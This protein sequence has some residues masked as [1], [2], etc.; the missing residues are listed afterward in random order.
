MDGANLLRISPDKGIPGPI[1]YRNLLTI[2]GLLLVLSAPGWLYLL[3]F[4]SDWFDYSSALL[5]VPP[6]LIIHSVLVGIASRQDGFL[7]RVMLVGTLAKLACASAFLYMAFHLFNAAADA[8]HYFDQGQSYFAA[9]QANG[10]FLLLQPFWSNN[11]IYMLSGLVQTV[12]GYDLQTT[13]VLFALLSFW[14]EYFC[15]RA[16][17]TAVPLEDRSQPAL[18]LFLLPSLAFW[19]API[20]KD[21]AVLL[22]IGLTAY[23]L[24]KLSSE[25]VV[26]G[27]P[28]A[29]IGIG[30]VALVRPH[31]A[32][33]I[34]TAYAFPFLASRTRRGLGGMTIKV[35]G[36]PLLVAV[37]LYLAFS[38]QSFLQL[39][40]VSRSGAVLQKINKNSNYGGSAFGG[41]ASP[42]QRV[43]AA[44]VLF[45]RP[46]P[47]EV[48]NA[49]SAIAAAEGLFL[50]VLVWKR[51]KQLVL[52]IRNWRQ[53]PFVFFALVFVLEFSI[54]FSTA[55]SNLGLLVR[56]RVMA[57]PFLIFVLCAREV[58]QEGYRL[59][60]KAQTIIHPTMRHVD[61]LVYP[62]Q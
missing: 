38:A 62:V 41:A 55:I 14:G 33:M 10:G 47:W 21:S 15:Y 34:A 42:A 5:Q 18:L 53:N 8:L 22:F 50:A 52:V 36:L 7:R 17:C 2:L 19:S 23:G 31:V 1:K 16:F 54:V 26:G 13:T 25:A 57:L 4:A 60:A 56:Q 11:F 58:W 28:L 61:D 20:G 40:D 9:M 43:L 44:P 45:F 6:V 12:V 24:A 32:L 27:L 59:S 29:L 3:F 48:R 30:G 35:L 39:E 51:R 46:F 49:Q 37:M